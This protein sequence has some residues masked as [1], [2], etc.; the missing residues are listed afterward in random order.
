MFLKCG[1]AGHRK[2]DCTKVGA[3]DEDIPLSGAPTY[4]VESVWDIGNVHVDGGWEVKKNPKK[5]SPAWCL[6]GLTRTAF[7]SRTGQE[8]RVAAKRAPT[9][10]CMFQ[11]L[12]EEEEFARKRRPH[13]H[14]MWRG[15]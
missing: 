12:Q 13:V 2:Q 3:I 14:G 7:R 9:N 5:V 8:N 10:G 6:P 4:H 15:R 1:E 11:A